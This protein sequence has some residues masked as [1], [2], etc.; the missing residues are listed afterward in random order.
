MTGSRAVFLLAITCVACRGEEAK[1]RAP[2]SADFGTLRVVAIPNELLISEAGIG[3][4]KLGFSLDSARKIEPQLAFSR[5]SD[6]EG[7]ALVLVTIGPDSLIA[8]LGEE[9][10]S[11]PVNTSKP[12]RSVETMSPSF[13][14]E[15]GIHAGSLVTDVEKVYGPIKEV[16]KSEIESREFIT[17]ANQPPGLQFRLDSGAGVFGPDSTVTTR[18]TPGARIFSIAVSS[19]S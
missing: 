15:Q 14:A 10:P 18:F 11:A 3:P 4:V 8:Y 1:E 5:T 2:V 12:V 13:N 9:D 17:F 16:F 7:V 19:S 6:G